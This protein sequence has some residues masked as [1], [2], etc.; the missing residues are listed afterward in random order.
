MVG[1]DATGRCNCGAVG[2]RIEG[3]EL[4]V[5]GCHCENCRVQS[6]AAY[7][8]NIIAKA[9]NVE[10]TG[11][12]ATYEDRRTNSGQPVLREFCPACGSPI[13][14]VVTAMPA[15]VAV[16][17]GTADEPGRFAP[18]LHVWTRSKLPWVEIPA[19]VACFE[20]EAG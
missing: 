3:P 6:G 13:R 2:W 17:A 20:E 7:S 11:V 19:G 18:T 15:I 4:A 16:K 8:V 1:T 10:V 14:S 12:I 5:V 9:R